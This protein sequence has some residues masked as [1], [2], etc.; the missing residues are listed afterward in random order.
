MKRTTT[1][2]VAAA[3]QMKTLCY[4]TSE[5]TGKPS[6]NNNNNTKLVGQRKKMLTLLSPPS[7]E[8]SSLERLG[9]L[10]EYRGPVKKDWESDGS[11][12]F[13]PEEDGSIVSGGGGSNSKVRKDAPILSEMWRERN[14]H[15]MNF[16]NGAIST[17]R[18]ENEI[19]SFTNTNYAAGGGKRETVTKA[20]V[21][22]TYF[23]IHV[24]PFVVRVETPRYGGLSMFVSCKIR[25][26]DRFL[27]VDMEYFEIHKKVRIV[28]SSGCG[29]TCDSHIAV[30]DKWQIVEIVTRI[31]DIYED[32]MKS[33]VCEFEN[34]LV[35]DDAVALLL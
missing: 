33:K 14:S 11:L 32:H 15:L 24:G 12:F 6:N 5:K 35:N 29:N 2:P 21:K 22:R 1:S 4:Y 17:I 18:R 25:T 31:H 3:R 23:E 16:I 20:A 27:D 9:L 8:S 30:K 34:I 26:K 7:A 13:F 19:L 28:R 10:M